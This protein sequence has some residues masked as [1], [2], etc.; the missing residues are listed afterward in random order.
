[1]KKTFVFVCVLFA[2][3]SASAASEQIYGSLIDETLAKNEIYYKAVRNLEKAFNDVC[4]D[5]F[6]EGDYPPES[7]DFTCTVNVKTKQIKNCV[8]AFAG[9]FLIPNEKTGAIKKDS[10]VSYCE[11]SPKMNAFDFI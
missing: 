5:T 10:K 9:T 8:W 4:G 3:L 2:A 1:M 7:I 11:F 6:C